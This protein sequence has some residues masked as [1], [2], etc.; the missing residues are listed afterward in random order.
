MKLSKYDKVIGTYKICISDFFYIG[1]L[2]SGYFRD[3]PIII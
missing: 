1:D 3:L 2:S